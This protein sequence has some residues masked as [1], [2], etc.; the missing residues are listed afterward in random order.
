VL[1][2]VFPIK[3]TLLLKASCSSST[4]LFLI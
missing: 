1:L 4:Y 3:R 2:A